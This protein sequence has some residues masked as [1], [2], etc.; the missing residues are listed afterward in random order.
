MQFFH[1]KGLLEG[2]GFKGQVGF[3]LRLENG[4][5]LKCENPCPMWKMHLCSFM[6]FY[7]NV[8]S[9]SKVRI[10]LKDEDIL[11]GPYNFKGLLGGYNIVLRLRLELHLEQGWLSVVG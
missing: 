9:T 5:L 11:A 2:L 4:K 10:F 8:H 7:Q 3:K 1:K 6:C